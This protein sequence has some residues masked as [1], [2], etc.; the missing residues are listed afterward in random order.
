MTH[1]IDT[2]PPQPAG[3]PKPTIAEIVMDLA[4]TPVMEADLSATL[5]PA[6]R[7][8]YPDMTCAQLDAAIRTEVTAWDRQMGQCS[9][10]DDLHAARA[11]DPD[12]YDD[13]RRFGPNPGA[14]HDTPQK[15]VAAYRAWTDATL[16]VADLVE[17]IL[18]RAT[19]VD[20]RPRDAETIADT[21]M[22]IV[23]AHPRRDELLKYGVEQAWRA[24]KL[25][26]A[27]HD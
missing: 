9:F 6:V 11:L 23:Y 1:H 5:V 16:P 2:F 13:G 27:R 22:R 26:G 7:E 19:P 3:K 21:M 8:H 14:L 15:L 17:A 4:K 24:G 10:W 18:Q 25:G 12:W 20:A